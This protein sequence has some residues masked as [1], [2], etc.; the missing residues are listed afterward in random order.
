MRCVECGLESGSQREAQRK[1]SEQLELA[2]LLRERA[3]S[4]LD[5]LTFRLGPNRRRLRLRLR[6]QHVRRRR[7]VRHRRLAS[8]RVQVVRRLPVHLLIERAVAAVHRDLVGPPAVP[9]YV[10]VLLVRVRRRRREKSGRRAT[11]RRERRARRLRHGRTRGLAVVRVQCGGRK[12]SSLPVRVRSRVGVHSGVGVGGCA[13]LQ[14][15]RLRLRLIQKLRGGLPAE[16]V[17]RLWRRGARSD[18]GLY[19]GQTLVSG[20][21]SAERQLRR[22]SCIVR[23]HVTIRIQGSRLCLRRMSPHRYSCIQ[24]QRSP[25]MHNN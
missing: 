24:C 17:D 22:D 3:A 4:R 13:L 18:R 7:Q 2:R 8:L 12:L 5:R 15:L 21:R 16:R 25:G 1:S 9:V 11:R 14:R 23:I 19:V 6:L 10:A 20:F